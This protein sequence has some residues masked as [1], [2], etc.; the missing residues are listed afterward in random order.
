MKFEVRDR[1]VDIMAPYRCQ[2]THASVAR[3]FLRRTKGSVVEISWFLRELARPQSLQNWYFTL[4]GVLKPLPKMAF[5][6]DR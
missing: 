2:G 6:S 3:Q 4:S 1:I 5:D